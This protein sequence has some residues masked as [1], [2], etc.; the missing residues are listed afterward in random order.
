MRFNLGYLGTGVGFVLFNEEE[1][2]ELNLPKLR[3][4]WWDGLGVDLVFDAVYLAREHC[5]YEK[6]IYI[7]LEIG[8]RYV[9]DTLFISRLVISRFNLFISMSVYLIHVD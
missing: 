1:E 6:I 2:V 9:Y 3:G 4:R 5:L 8:L 7:V